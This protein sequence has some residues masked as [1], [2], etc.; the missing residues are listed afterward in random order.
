M[1]CAETLLM[2]LFYIFKWKTAQS[3]KSTNATKNYL[4]MTNWLSPS[5][6]QVHFHSNSTFCS[7]SGHTLIFSTNQN[8][9][10]ILKTF[11]WV[12]VRKH[13]L[14]PSVKLYHTL[15]YA[16]GATIS[17][18]KKFFNETLQLTLRLGLAPLPRSNALAYFLWLLVVESQPTA[19]LYTAS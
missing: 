4:L 10:K 9:T 8:W 11:R 1:F 3:N 12:M 5:Y 14:P 17:S 16:I 19:N 18:G 15:F 13:C 2:R 7:S 6:D